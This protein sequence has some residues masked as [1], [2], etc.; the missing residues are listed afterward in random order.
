MF[1]S[2]KLRSHWFCYM[3][4]CTSHRIHQWRWALSILRLPQPPPWVCSWQQTQGLRGW[5]WSPH[6]NDR[7]VSLLATSCAFI[8]T[9]YASGLLPIPILD[10][11]CGGQPHLMPLIPLTFMCS[12]CTHFRI[13][14]FLTISQILLY[15]VSPDNQHNIS[16]NLNNFIIQWIVFIARI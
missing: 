15:W 11:Q 6:T 16:W 5:N 3:L 10:L 12:V 9:K 1:L 4:F 2:I 8:Q 14:S 13:M 7:Q